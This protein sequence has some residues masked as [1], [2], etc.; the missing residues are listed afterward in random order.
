MSLTVI[1]TVGGFAVITYSIKIIVYENHTSYIFPLQQSSEP[2]VS[3]RNL[4]IDESPAG[5]F[6]FITTYTP[7][8]NW[9]DDYSNGKAGKFDGLIQLTPIDLGNNGY[10]K[11]IIES[12]SMDLNKLSSLNPIPKTSLAQMCST[13][14]YVYTVPYKCASG[15]HGPGEDCGLSG[16]DRAGYARMSN[17]V[18]TCYDVDINLPTIGN[19]GGKLTT[20]T[21]PPKYNPCP[22]T[23]PMIDF[24]WVR[25]ESKADPERFNGE[26]RDFMKVHLPITAKGETI[27]IDTKRSRESY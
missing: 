26:N 22:K 13:I 19:G 14:T 9:I 25:V 17:A 11:N 21:T 1:E 27:I 12:R 2:A 3:F 15:Q 10:Q 20:H 4:T 18:T 7:T 6:A 16:S 24:K 23:I 8:K 5:T